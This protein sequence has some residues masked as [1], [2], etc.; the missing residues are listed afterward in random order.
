MTPSDLRARCSVV[1]EMPAWAASRSALRASI[2]V[3]ARISRR[4][5]TASACYG[6]A[7][8]SGGRSRSVAVWLVTPSQTTRAQLYRSSSTSR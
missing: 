6:A 2:G 1:L 5:S 3:S 4:I 8:G 7:S